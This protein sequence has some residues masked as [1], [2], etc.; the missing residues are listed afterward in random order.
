MDICVEW[1]V[2]REEVV[3]MATNLAL[4]DGLIREA[5]ERGHHKTK[6]EAVN[7][8]LK[9]YIR[10]MKQQEIVDLFGSIVYDPGYDYKKQ[11]KRK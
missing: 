4:D 6:K 11:R 9:L 1:C 5:K 10:H 8:A 7:E 3:E 2:I